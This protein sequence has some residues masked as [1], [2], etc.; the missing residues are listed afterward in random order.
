MSN[1]GPNCQSVADAKMLLQEFGAVTTTVIG[2]GVLKGIGRPLLG[3][4]MP[5][6]NP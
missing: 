3:M 5:E 1:P 6:A 2:Y 4:F